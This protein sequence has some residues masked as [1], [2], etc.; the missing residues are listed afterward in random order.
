MRIHILYTANKCHTNTT[1]TCLSTVSVMSY[2]SQC[3]FLHF[4]CN[5]PL[6]GLHSKT[7]YHYWSIY[8]VLFSSDYRTKI[9][10]PYISRSSIQPVWQRTIIHQFLNLSSNPSNPTIQICILPA[11]H[12]SPLRVHISDPNATAPRSNHPNHRY[13]SLYENLCISMFRYIF[14]HR[15]FLPTSICTHSS[16]I[17]IRTF[18]T[19][20]KI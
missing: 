17:H 19:H 6:L 11:R 2:D 1:I 10:Y 9:R 4:N 5:C 8:L 15:T 7:A 13:N 20:I 12:G 14:H 16:E 3:D 18:S